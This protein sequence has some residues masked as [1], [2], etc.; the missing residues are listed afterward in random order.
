[1]T[2]PSFY[3]SSG[4]RVYITDRPGFFVRPEVRKNSLSRN[5][6]TPMEKCKSCD[7]VRQWRKLA[8][9]GF[10]EHGAAIEPTPKNSGA[11]PNAFVVLPPVSPANYKQ[12]SARKYRQPDAQVFRFRVAKWVPNLPCA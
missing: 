12:I 6:D 1:M 2:S 9:V 11:F 3:S 8:Q 4:E 7:I 5:A 10:L